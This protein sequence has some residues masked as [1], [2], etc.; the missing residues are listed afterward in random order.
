MRLEQRLPSHLSSLVCAGLVGLGLPSLALAQWVRQEPGTKSRLRGVSVVDRDTAWV[1]GAGGTILRT[2]DGGAHWI[3][4]PIPGADGDDLRDVHA[5]DSRSAFVLAIGPGKRSRVLKTGDGGVRWTVSF[6]NPDDTGFFDAV[7]FWD[8][9]HGLVQGDPVDGRFAIFSTS[10]GGKDWKRRVG[11]I[12]PSLPG[13][14]AFAASGTSLVVQGTRHAWF[15]TGGARIARVFRSDDRGANWMVADTPIAAGTPSAGIFSLCFR[16]AEHGVAVGG[17]YRNP[18]Q[19]GRIVARSTDGGRTWTLPR[20]PGPRAFRSA[21]AYLP[22]RSTPTMIA[23]GPAGADVSTD[24]GDSWQPLGAIGFHALDL[25]APDAGW[26][27]GE[28]GRIG[29]FTGLR[30]D[31]RQGSVPRD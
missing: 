24:D 17:D 31:G 7:A 13:E 1:T 22:G 14:G 6:T 8:P 30:L 19:G 25:A 23:V 20:G 21:V 18:E 12:P 28:D 9:D 11:S 15:G 4:R 2:L 16:D 3:A 29:R 26:A 27:V 5:V 10:D